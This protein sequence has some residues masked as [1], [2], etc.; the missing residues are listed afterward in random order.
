MIYATSELGIYRV[1]VF[2]DMETEIDH[3]N[4]VI[5]IT[6]YNEVEPIRNKA[7][8]YSLSG[9][10]YYSSES[11]F[12]NRGEQTEIEYTMEMNASLPVPLGLRF[13]P[14]A[15]INE[16]AR[17]ITQWRIEEIAQGFIDRSLQ[18]FKG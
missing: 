13:M 11:I 12:H 7:G 10:G 15:L 2:C 8:M 16:I 9:Q 4:G 6:P 14:G 17:N 3:E 18:A 1:R 5:H